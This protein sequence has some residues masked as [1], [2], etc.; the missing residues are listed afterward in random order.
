MIA[1]EGSTIAHSSES[2]IGETFEFPRPCNDEEAPAH[3]QNG[4]ARQSR[5]NWAQAVSNAARTRQRPATLTE[6]LEALERSI[7]ALE[8]SARTAKLADI[9]LIPVLAGQIRMLVCRSSPSLNPLLQRCAGLLDIPLTVFAAPTF[10]LGGELP[11]VG[12]DF[13]FGVTRRFQKEQAI[14]LDLWL[15]DNGAVVGKRSY[16]RD[17]LLCAIANK[18]GGAHHSPVVDELTHH[19][20]MGKSDGLQIHDALLIELSDN[21]AALGRAVLAAHKGR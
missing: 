7:R 5:Q 1:A 4:K 9:A 12:F 8:H 15:A 11:A 19:L 2:K 10:P 14:D 18:L 21:I 16:T 17:Q 3:P 13:S 6:N 20:M